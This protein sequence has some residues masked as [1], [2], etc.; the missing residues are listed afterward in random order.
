MF[1][2]YVSAFL[3]TMLLS[4]L[5]WGGSVQPAAAERGIAFGLNGVADWST[6]H[7]F[8]DVMKS[9]RRWI[10]HLP[11][12]WGGVDFEDMM[13]E[14]VFDEHGWP[15]RM[16]ENVTKLESLI[17]TDQSPDAI[18]L[19]GR[20]VVL[21]DGQ[22]ELS[23][24]GRAR[25]ATREPGS[26]VFSYSPGSGSVGI[27]ISATN[28]DDPIRN[29]RVIPEKHLETYLAGGVFNPD[30][31]ERIQKVQVIRFMDWMFTNGS[32]IET[33]ADMPDTRD[34]SYGWRGV[35][36]TV[37]IDL[38]NSIQADPWFNIPH[39]ADDDLVRRFAETVKS[40]IDQSRVVY[41]EYSNEVWNFIFEQAHWAGQQ[42][43]KL[44]GETGDGWVQF[45][46][47]KAASAMKIWT[48]VYAEDAEA[49]LNRVVSVHT[50]WPELEQSILLGDRAQAA[51]GFAP[52]QM[53][54]SYAVT[55][56]F[57]G[58][59]GQPGTLDTAFK[60]SLSK[61]E[62]DGRAKG[63]SRVAL[64]EYVNEHRFDGM[65]QMAAEIVKT[66]SLRELT[67]DTWPYHAQV[68]SRHGLEFIM[69][70]G[71]THATPTFDSV[72]DEQLVDFLITFNYSPEMA[73]IYREALSA[74]GGLTD[75]PFNVFVDVAGPSK[76]GSWGALRHLSDDNP[77]WRVVDPAEISTTKN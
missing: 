60:T 58:E 33:W 17:L 48:D 77:R 72:E 28:A 9:G 22:G 25:V 4:V 26:L 69:Y 40:E 38:A 64:R 34:F 65:H 62:T 8:I 56:Y 54:D 75:S 68:A 3:F 49:R 47:Y 42:A 31:L 52:V 44:W 66:G 61:A 63:L 57:A 73:D 30:W 32:P 41:V 10:G 27:A 74:W 16:P 15:V 46:G 5:S 39:L 70:E 45:Y 19:S 14:G 51:L 12:Q 59:L 20:Y 18:H 7:P 35:P 53:F 76:W 2:K 55:G 43:E 23:V 1:L 71:G 21:Y 50:G 11:N 29:I 67:E 24:S 36:L 13:A 6:Q 37:M